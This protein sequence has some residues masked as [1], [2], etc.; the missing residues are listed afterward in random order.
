M[1][2]LWTRKYLDYSLKE[3]AEDYALSLIISLIMAALVYLVGLLQ[4]NVIALL[5]LQVFVGVVTYVACS[6]LLK[7]KPF[8]YVLNMLKG[9]VRR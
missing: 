3:I 5:A 1:Y 6:V 2:M 7:L 8:L 4:I 9:I